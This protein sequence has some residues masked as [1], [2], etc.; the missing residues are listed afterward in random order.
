[1]GHG[2]VCTGCCWLLLLLLFVGGGMNL[3]W[4]GAIALYVLA[5]K[6]GPAGRW[7]GRGAG[8]LLVVW[9]AATL[10]AAR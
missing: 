7:I 2:I 8:A 1:L 6:L 4:I 5:H 10:L 3:A 9:G